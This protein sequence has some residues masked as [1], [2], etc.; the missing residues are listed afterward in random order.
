MKAKS[1]ALKAPT[2][3]KFKMVANPK[4]P[5]IGQNYSI[6]TLYERS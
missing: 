4:K 5:Q 1:S 6:F 2:F 3:Q